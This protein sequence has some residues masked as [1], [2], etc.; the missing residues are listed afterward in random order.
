MFDRFTL[1]VGILTVLL[2][3]AGCAHLPRDTAG[4]GELPTERPPIDESYDYEINVENDCGILSM[5]LPSIPV[6]LA[7]VFDLPEIEH[8]VGLEWKESDSFNFNRRMLPGR[9]LFGLKGDYYW[10][11][12]TKKAK[13]Y[14]AIPLVYLIRGY[15]DT[16]IVMLA[17]KKKGRQ[18]IVLKKKVS[19]N[20]KEIDLENMTKEERKTVEKEMV[21]LDVNR[22]KAD[23]KY[24][25]KRLG[26]LQK[27]ND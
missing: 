5:S 9:K 17:I 7:L 1:F 25:L 15:F 19:F 2:L 4:I 8:I 3:L 21:H 22:I 6:R 13:L 27:H 20:W 14:I 26:F 24:R 18:L 23:I 16:E 11:D 10:N 12:K